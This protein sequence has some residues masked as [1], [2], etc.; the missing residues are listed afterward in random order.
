MKDDLSSERALW[1]MA[2]LLS[3]QDFTKLHPEKAL[4]WLTKNAEELSFALSAITNR[5]KAGPA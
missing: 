1:Q 3:T 5:P 2:G 4:E